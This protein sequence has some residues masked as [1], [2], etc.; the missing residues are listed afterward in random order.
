MERLRE[1]PGTLP[2]AEPYEQY[3][4]TVGFV[5]VADAFAEIIRFTGYPDS[6]TL[7]AR[8]AAARVRI[9]DLTG[10]AVGEFGVNAGSEIETHL[11]G[12]IVEAQE[13]VAAAG[14]ELSV[15]GKWRDPKAAGHGG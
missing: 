12:R 3:Q 1:E 14:A 11:T 15:V 4:G 8:V 9:R 13:V 2:G 5:A 10:N 6:I 7:A